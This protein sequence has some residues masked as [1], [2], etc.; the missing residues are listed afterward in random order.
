MSEYEAIRLLLENKMSV[1]YG[2]LSISD[3]RFSS[4]Y[5][6][7]RCYQVYLESS[8]RFAEN[9]SDLD[10]AI[11]KFLELKAQTKPYVY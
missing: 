6:G 5:R 11:E 1:D 4:G 9:Y 2:R 7:K 8:N 3:L 10:K